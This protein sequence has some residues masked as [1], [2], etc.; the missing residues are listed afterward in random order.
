MGIKKV[1]NAGTNCEIIRKTE[2]SINYQKL[3]NKWTQ[4]FIKP[5]VG[6]REETANIIKRKIETME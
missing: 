3:I 5:D 4:C 6:R 2:I 1:F